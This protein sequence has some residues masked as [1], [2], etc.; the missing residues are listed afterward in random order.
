MPVA[1]FLFV[2]TATDRHAQ[3]CD[4]SGRSIW[5]SPGTAQTIHARNLGAQPGHFLRVAAALLLKEPDFGSRRTLGGRL[6]T[7]AQNERRRRVPRDDRLE[8]GKHAFR[9]KLAMMAFRRN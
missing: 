1:F 6:G 4:P 9:N 5:Q 7:S 2:E 8:S 3:G